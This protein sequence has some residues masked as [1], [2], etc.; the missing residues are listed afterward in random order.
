MSAPDGAR[1]AVRT[2]KDVIGELDAASTA[3]RKGDNDRADALRHRL[4]ELGEVAA[5]AEH[6]AALAR[7]AVAMQWD[8]VVDALWK[9]DWLTLRT[10]P[11]PDRSPDGEA[12]PDDV[13]ALIVAVERAADAVRDAARRWTFGRRER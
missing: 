6:H 3:L 9:E 13:K 4:V 10:P 8:T 5:D 7:Y 1:D 2:Y 12:T 11:Q